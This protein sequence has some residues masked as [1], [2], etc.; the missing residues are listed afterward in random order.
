LIKAADKVVKPRIA[1]P[2]P[3]SYDLDYSGRALPAY[4][5]AVEAAGGQPVIVPLKSSPEEVARIVTSCAAVLLPGSKADV[6]PQK[7]NAEKNPKTNPADQ[8][9]DAADELLLQDAYNLR[10]PVFGICYGL[11]SLNVWRTGTLVQHI[12]SR[13]NHSAG[14][15]VEMAHHVAVLPNSLLANEIPGGE[16]SK[17]VPVNSS[18]HQ[19]ADVVGDGLRA[20]AR[21]PED[22]VIEAI[23]GTVPGHYVIAVQWHPERSFEQD[24]LSSN[25]FRA[26]VE[27]A[28]QWNQRQS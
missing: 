1:I 2:E 23:E 7:Y 10:K 28:R 15:R 3:C 19:S 27:S 25:L 17:A 26:F 21:C 14:A 18:H 16:E 22:G 11:Q 24:Q 8:L 6:D 13:V 4:L 5:L 9:R 20:V 12:E